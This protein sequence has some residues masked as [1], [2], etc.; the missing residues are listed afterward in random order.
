MGASL[1]AMAAGQLAVMSDGQPSSRASSL[2]QGFSSGGRVCV[3]PP[4]QCGSEL[5]RDGG[6]SVGGDVEWAAVIASKLGSHRGSRMETGFAPITHSQCGSELARD[7]GGSVGGDVEWAAVI[8]SKLGSHRGCRVET[9]FVST[10][11][12]SVGARCWRGG[13]CLYW[14][15]TCTIELTCTRACICSAPPPRRMPRTGQASR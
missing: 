4:F 10:P 9:G 3:H 1:L 2:P 5:A 11:P 6:G 7:G 8:A 12:S 13:L 14:C 15:C